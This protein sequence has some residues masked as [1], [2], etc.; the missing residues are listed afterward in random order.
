MND[1]SI[2]HGIYE[3]IF[4]KFFKHITNFFDNNADSN[5]DRDDESF[6]IP[7]KKIKNIRKRK[8][9]AIKEES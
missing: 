3:T 8:K 1:F 9:Q 6:E 2:R 5:I 4:N 7:L